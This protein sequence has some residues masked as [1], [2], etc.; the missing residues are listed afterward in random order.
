[1]TS[2]NSDKEYYAAADW[3]EKEMTVKPGSATA[4]RGT[5]A[6]DLGRRMVARST[7][8]RPVLDPSAYPGKYSRV[9]QVRLPSD[10]AGSLDALAR[11]QNQ[12]LSDL[13]R[14]ALTDYVST[15]RAD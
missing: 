10:L 2:M 8:G 7:G 13:M 4:L 6:A 14:D 3:A 11:A 5:A 9:R 15:H 1:M 12:R